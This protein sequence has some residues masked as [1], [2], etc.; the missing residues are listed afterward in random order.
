MLVYSFALIIQLKPQGRSILIVYKFRK[1][2]RKFPFSKNSNKITAR[3][4][5]EINFKTLGP[6]DLRVT[7]EV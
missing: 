3:L 6:W 1:S 5:Q 4:Y 7:W 2:P